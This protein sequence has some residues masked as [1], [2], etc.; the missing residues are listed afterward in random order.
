LTSAVARRPRRARTSWS[1]QRG[2]EVRRRTDVRQRPYRSE[3]PETRDSIR[4]APRPDFPRGR[5]AHPVPTCTTEH[6]CIR[7]VRSPSFGS[8][9]PLRLVQR[10]TRSTV[11]TRAE[12]SWPPTRGPRQVPEDD[13]DE[14][15]TGRSEHRSRDA[16]RKTRLRSKHARTIS[17]AGRALATCDAG[18]SSTWTLALRRR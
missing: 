9:R 2:H 3:P 17:P 16:E 11:S 10:I 8:W 15:R 12:A 13:H 14:Q 6:L 18:S 1:R 7:R 5:A 4:S